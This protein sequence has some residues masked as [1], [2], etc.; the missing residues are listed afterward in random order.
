MIETLVNVIYESN[1]KLNNCYRKCY[2]ISDDERRYLIEQIKYLNTL[3]QLEL[4][5]IKS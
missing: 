3:L 4:K 2:N 1:F 5:A